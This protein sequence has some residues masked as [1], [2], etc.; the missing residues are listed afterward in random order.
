M[1][2]YAIALATL[3]ALTL[4]GCSSSAEPTPEPDSTATTTTPETATPRTTSAIPTTTV[5]VEPAEYWLRENREGYLTMVV[6]ADYT[7]EQL[8]DAFLEVRRMYSNTS[9]GGWHVQV[10]C[11]D[12]QMSEG[13]ARQANGKFAIDNL[14]AARTGLDVGDYEF[15]PLNGRR[16]CSIDG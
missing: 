12:G 6:D 1:R 11:G 3:G 5:E 15:K 16:P 2:R 7:D 4:A 14:G 8:E 13:G 9:E 10:D